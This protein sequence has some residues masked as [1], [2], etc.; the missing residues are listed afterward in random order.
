[1]WSKEEA[2]I[3][4]V[5]FFTN[6][7]IYMKKHTDLFERKIKWVN[8]RT[9]VSAVRFKIEADNKTARVVIDIIDNDEGVMD[10]FYEQFTEFKVLLESDMDEL[11]WDK[12][13]YNDT[14]LRSM[15]IYTELTGYSMN[16]E[17]HWGDLYRFFEKNMLALHE[18]WDNSKDIFIDLEN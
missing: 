17:E 11:T 12:E 5:K 6:F 7:G 16:N 18:F 9:G 13:Y 4:R 14:H 8:Y 15:R 3:K 1:M 10:L 2:R